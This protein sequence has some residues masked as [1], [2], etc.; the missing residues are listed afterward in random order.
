MG[1]AVAKVP[2]LSELATDIN[3]N[4]E[5]AASHYGQSFEHIVKAGLLIAQAKRQVGHGEWAKWVKANLKFGV[6]Q[7][8]NYMKIASA[9]AEMRNG[10]SDLSLRKA[11]HEL[12]VRSGRLVAQLPEQPDDEPEPKG[13]IG[14]EN[15]NELVRQGREITGYRAGD[16]NDP[17]DEPEPV[18]EPDEAPTI[19]LEPEQST[20]QP[21]GEDASWM[22]EA[23]TG[24][25]KVWRSGVR[26]AT[27]EE[28]DKYISGFAMY[29]LKGFLGAEILA[30][31]N[32][33][34]MAIRKAS[35]R[36]KRYT[37]CFEHGTCGRLGWTEVGT[38]TIIAYR[39]KQY[40][41]HIAAIESVAARQ[42]E[43]AEFKIAL[44]ATDA[45]KRASTLPQDGRS[46]V[47]MD[48]PAPEL[49]SAID[50][51]GE[52]PP[53]LDRRRARIVG[54]NNV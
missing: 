19:M 43:L 12:A 13:V 40:I 11:I 15:W 24:D 20:A 44:A 51:L 37:L 42:D 29:E 23:V 3:E 48:D 4:Y 30:S 22:V 41:A 54:G 28:A 36:S 8:S 34:Q 6:R 27:W 17:P 38:T 2:T 14:D 25:G 49:A 46:E 32:K 16:G 26:V 35:K 53:C 9:P 31:A 10:V 5:L 33:P 45:Q 18:V 50:D 1:T 52:I 21:S 47:V 7:A 39:R